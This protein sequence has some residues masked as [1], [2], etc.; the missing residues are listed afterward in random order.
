MKKFI[1]VA[2][3]KIIVVEVFGQINESKIWV[4]NYDTNCYC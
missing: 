1:S 2:H 3:N 4:I